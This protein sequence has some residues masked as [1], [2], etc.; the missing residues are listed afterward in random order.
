MDRFANLDFEEEDDPEYLEFVR[1]IKRLPI[2]RKEAALVGYVKHV[3][4]E[5]EN[6][7]F[8]VIGRLHEMIEWLLNTGVI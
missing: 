4:V 1:S 7:G 5:C 2:E 6:S 3:I 8:S